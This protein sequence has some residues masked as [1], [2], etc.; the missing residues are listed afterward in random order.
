MIKNNSHNLKKTRRTLIVF[1]FLLI[2]IYFIFLQ[3]KSKSKLPEQSLTNTNTKTIQISP[4]LNSVENEFYKVRLNLPKDYTI[5]CMDSYSNNQRCYIRKNNEIMATVN[6]DN[7]Q[8]YPEFKNT[9][10]SS[11]FDFILHIM[12]NACMMNLPASAATKSGAKYATCT[13]INNYSTSINAYGAYFYEITFKYGGTEEQMIGKITDPYI[14]F[15]LGENGEKKVI[16][17]EP[18]AGTEVKNE[19]INTIEK[20]H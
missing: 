15:D 8:G 12:Y 17:I 5:S 13:E 4:T 11:I 3:S 7:E 2:G 18:L 19:I 9:N 1:L 6:F 16:R 14:F 10:T 20:L